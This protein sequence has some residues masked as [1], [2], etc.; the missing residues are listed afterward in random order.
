MAGTTVQLHAAEVRDLARGR[1][2]IAESAVPP[3]AFLCRAGAAAPGS[4]VH[5]VVGHLPAEALA[6]VVVVDRRST[7]A[8]VLDGALLESFTSWGEAL[9]G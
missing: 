8:A 7:V 2:G 1:L 9:P 3:L 4:E 6:L 5:D